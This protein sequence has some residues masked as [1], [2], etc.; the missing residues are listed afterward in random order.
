MND[1]RLGKNATI[2]DLIELKTLPDPENYLRNVLY[3]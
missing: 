3:Q 1:P 2:K